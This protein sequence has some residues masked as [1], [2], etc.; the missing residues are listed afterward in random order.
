VQPTLVTDPGFDEKPVVHLR[1]AVFSPN[2]MWYR[3]NWSCDFWYNLQLLPT[4]PSPGGTYTRLLPHGT[5]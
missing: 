3:P 5:S 2:S 4:Y 1:E